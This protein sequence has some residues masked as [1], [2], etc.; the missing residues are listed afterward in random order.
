V[1]VSKD[2]EAEIVRMSTVEGW[3][4]GTAANQLGV[5]HDVVDRLMAERANVPV[6][7]KPRR[8]MADLYVPFI[9]ETLEKYPRLPASVLYRMAKARGYAGRCEG[10][11][12][13]IVRRLRPRPAAEA[14]LRLRTLPGEE[15]QVDWACFGKILVGKAERSLVLFVMV[16][17]WSRKIFARF[18]LN[19]RLEN[20]LRGHEEAFAS[21]GGVPR[22]SK[23]DNLKSAVLERAADAIRF[24]PKFLDYAIRYGFEPRPVA[25]A[26]GNEKGRVERAIRYLR[27][28]FF[29]GRAWKNLADLNRQ[30]DEWLRDVANNRPCPGDTAMTVA[31]AFAKEAPLLLPLPANP[32]PTEERVAVTAGK[33]PYVRF[34]SNDYTVPHTYVRRDLEVVAT[35]DTVR[36]LDGNEVVATHARSYSKKEQIE[37]ERHIKEL[38]AHKKRARPERAID[39][40]HH[41]LPH[42]QELFTQLAA[43]GENLGAAT[44]SLIRL[45]HEFGAHAVDEALV[46]ALA[47]GAPHPNSVRCILDR[48]RHELG[49]PAPIAISFPDDHRAGKL[50]V[51]P[52]ALATY[53]SLKEVQPDGQKDQDDDQDAHHD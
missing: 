23:Y 3:P 19:A 44:S 11:F 42:S 1:T 7:A 41:A 9:K 15:A 2:L 14:Y 4:P 6:E 43:R 28:S 8:T 30:L 24:N 26:R 25:V 29:M 40:L 16:L 18:F 47:K 35:L 13:R 37:D 33:T 21:F 32:Y 31:E 49:L 10:H 46:E 36:V 5:H 17:S 52:H 20:F 53:D 38:V 48:K 27:T 51:T 22:R 50:T 34:D 45:V 39:R 12:R